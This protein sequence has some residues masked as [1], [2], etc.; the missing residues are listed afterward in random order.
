M[1]LD[2][3]NT[4][5]RETAE[6]AISNF[7]NAA[8]NLIKL[9]DLT[10]AELRLRDALKQADMTFGH[11]SRVVRHVLTIM[12]EFYRSQNRTDALASLEKRLELMGVPKDGPDELL[13][14]N[15]SHGKLIAV[16]RRSENLHVE[17]K[18]N[19]ARMST[20]VR[21]SCQILG[22]SLDNVDA[23]TVKQAWKLAI[24]DPS[25]HPDLGGEHETAILLNTARDKVL[26]WLEAQ[27]PKLFSKFERIVRHNN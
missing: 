13:N 5:P 19:P 21:K 25:A 10:Q 22:L 24:S 16:N 14:P 26:N 11:N 27:K 4:D 12:I 7:L 9:G 20:E 1:S 6:A 2:E 17:N 15:S 3:T 23:E 18:P 8:E